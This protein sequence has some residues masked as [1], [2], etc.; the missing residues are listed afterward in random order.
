MAVGVKAAEVS[1]TMVK[2]P[3]VR[4]AVQPPYVSLEL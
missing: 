3:V 1:E 4:E 2:I